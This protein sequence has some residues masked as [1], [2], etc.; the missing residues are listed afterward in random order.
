MRLQLYKPI[1]LRHRTAKWLQF[2]VISLSSY[3]TFRKAFCL[4]NIHWQVLQ[5]QQE[6]V[7]P[8]EA[9]NCCD[10][11]SWGEGQNYYDIKMLLK[12]VLLYKND[13]GSESR[14]STQT[15]PNKRVRDNK[16]MNGNESRRNI[17]RT[18]RKIVFAQSIWIHLPN[19]A[20]QWWS[21]V[22]SQNIS[23]HTAIKDDPIPQ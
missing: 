11:L 23:Q 1:C 7:L 16:R 22:V 21:R 4:W 15:F 6:I 13:T 2:L 8:S 5:V 20:N 9:Y 3:Q 17:Y 18:P 10:V 19:G 12:S 14:Q